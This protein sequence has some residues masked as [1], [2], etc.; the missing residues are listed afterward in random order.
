MENLFKSEWVSK[1]LIQLKKDWLSPC[2]T[3][4]RGTYLAMREHGGLIF[5]H[6]WLFYLFLS[7]PHIRGRKPQLWFQFPSSGTVEGSSGWS[8]QD[9]AGVVQTAD[10]AAH[11]ARA[12]SSCN[13]QRALIVINY[14]LR[15]WETLSISSLHYP[16]QT[17]CIEEMRDSGEWPQKTQ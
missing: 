9:L 14:K 4:V 3:T 16:K 2:V 5:I 6:N 10:T 8:T 15:P 12:S 1:N 17:Q 7:T 11:S 13:P